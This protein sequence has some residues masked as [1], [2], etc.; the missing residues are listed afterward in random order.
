MAQGTVD[1]GNVYVGLIIYKVG[2]CGALTVYERQGYRTL[3]CPKY[4]VFRGD[5]AVKEIRTKRAAFRWAR[6]N[7]EM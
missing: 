5:E 1:S 4:A 7:Q 6:Q 2:T 3:H